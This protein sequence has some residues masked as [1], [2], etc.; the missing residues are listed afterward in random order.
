MLGLEVDE[1][2]LL[3]YWPTSS[4]N[5]ELE[6]S[7]SFSPPNWVP[8]TTPSFV[9]EGQNLEILPMTSANQFYR[10]EYITP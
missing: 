2:Y 9:F 8:V 7:A 4:A 10:L 3:I 5:F 6:T 1:N